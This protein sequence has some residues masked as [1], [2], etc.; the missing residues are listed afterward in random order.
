MIVNRSRDLTC[1]CLAW[2]RDCPEQKSRLVHNLIAFSYTTK[3]HL[4]GSTDLSEL[5]ELLTDE[6]FQM[7]VDAITNRSKRPKKS[8]CPSKQSSP[9]NWILSP[10]IP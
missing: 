3:Q 5:N 2:I 7:L 4:R 10:P 9:V 6:E 1:Q 8:L